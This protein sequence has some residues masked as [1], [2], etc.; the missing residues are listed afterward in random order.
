MSKR[1]SKTPSASPPL[2]SPTAAAAA[3]E[4]K[5]PLPPA[6]AD[7]AIGIDLGT[8]YSCVGVWRA[9]NVEIIA[10]ELGN[11]TTP[12]YVAFTENE[13]ML[14]EAA[15]GQQDKNAV[16]TI[17]DA[18]RLIG[19]N[20]SDAV[21][22][23]DME[24]WPFKVVAKDGDKP[25]IQVT[26]KGE[27][28]TYWP[29]EIS[30]MVLGKMRS[31]AEAFLGRE[32]KQAVITV[33]AY[34]ND[35]QRQATKDA[36]TIAGLNTLRIINEPTAA[37]IAYGLDKTDGKVVGTGGKMASP[38]SNV[39]VFDLGGGTFDVSLL[40]IR[41]GIFEVKATAGN[42]HLGGGDFDARLV[43]H[44]ASEF[45]KKTGATLAGNTRALARLRT[46][47]ERAK[48]N[49][50]ASTKASI[51]IDSLVGTHD[52][53]T[54]ITRAKFESLCGD[55][56]RQCLEPVSKVLLDAKVDKKQVDE[57]VLVGGST[58][59][60][61]V[62]EMIK[63]Y[64][65]GKEPCRSVNPDEAVAY[66]AAV[67]AA[68]LS[69]ADAESISKILLLDVTALSLGVE[70]AGGMMHSLIKRNSTIPCRRQQI[71][72]TFAD[73]QTSVFVQV[74]EGERARTADNSLLGRF[75]LSGIPPAPAGTPQVVVTFDLDANGILNVSAE[76]KKTG[77]S[78]KIVISNDKG[79]LTKDQIDSMIQEAERYA[80][81]D[82]VARL[83]LAVR[84][85]LEAFITSVR[86]SVTSAGLSA[87]DSKIV[88]KAVDDASSWLSSKPTADK[89]TL[90]AKLNELST[91]CAKFVP[92]EES[93]SSTDDV[94][95]EEVEEEENTLQE[96]DGG[97][98]VST[99][100]RTIAP[101]PSPT[102]ASS[103]SFSEPPPEMGGGDLD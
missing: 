23:K 93:K 68:V 38:P 71:F 77:R 60:P 20:F 72:S 98:G 88:T 16:N 5:K 9:N 82:S 73:N 1:E 83:T 12:S 97:A 85:Q 63:S 4:K 37:A 17:F 59:I 40:S 57:V 6:A 46:Q 50:S 86:R 79:R 21:V 31:T 87:S 103:S 15:L 28:K 43:K 35:S 100:A 81:T 95:E 34:F 84:Q 11:R 55:L 8:T 96:E 7:V 42:T 53:Y 64:F 62:Q 51:E 19:R 10:N 66:G 36:A 91:L 101:S 14:G 49:L 2:P 29:E 39:L 26:L 58:R 76:E 90:E 69:G 48:R 52:L 70:L 33:P 54:T 99:P 102:A 27:T 56:F 78:T 13:R 44:L 24:S 61:R 65:G 80:D 94:E 25:A 22:Q 47:A 75:E 74:F 30:S 89:A 32:V 45:E 18:K 3:T 67:Q 92:V 41:D